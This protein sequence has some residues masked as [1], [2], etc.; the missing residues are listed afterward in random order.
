MRNA[1][2]IHIEK[3]MVMEMCCFID[4]KITLHVVVWFVSGYMIMPHKQTY[5]STYLRISNILIN[6]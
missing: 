4:M 6:M 5:I 2:K 3:L 1:E